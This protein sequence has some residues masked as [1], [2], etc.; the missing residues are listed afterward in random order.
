MEVGRARIQ[1]L[2]HLRDTKGLALAYLLAAVEALLLLIFALAHPILSAAPKHLVLLHTD[3][4]L[5]CKHHCALQ[6]EESPIPAIVLVPQIFS[7]A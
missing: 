7:V 6:K 4:E 2:A 1:K 3:Q 5:V